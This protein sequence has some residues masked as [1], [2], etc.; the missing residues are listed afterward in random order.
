M[1]DLVSVSNLTK[2]YRVKKGLWRKKEIYAL[3]EVSLSVKEGE[4]LAVVGESGSGKSTLGKIILRLERPTGGSVLFRGKDVFS[5][6]KEYT[7]HVSVVFQDPRNSL[8]PRMRVKE[9]IEEPLRVHGIKERERRVREVVERVHLEEEL[10]GKKPLQLSGGQAQR[11]AI[12]RAL[13]LEPE[14]IVADEPTASLDLSIQKEILNLFT[15]LNSRGIAFLFITHDV[16]VVEKIA[17]RVAV[18][19]G[20]HLMELGKKEEVL[21]NPLNPYTRYLLESVPVK[22][23][24]QRR[25]SESFEE[26]EAEVP[27][28]GCPF[29][30]RCPEASQECR[31]TLRRV[32]V[33]GRVVSCNLY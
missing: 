7:R 26:E 27:E 13:V 6:G 21:S 32:E 20:G 17:H 14:L 8:N 5:M 23:P 2:V 30:P 31:E 3:K 28:R 10:L 16:R 19:Y 15:E 24:R 9:I 4:I 29:Y 12:A 25:Q 1:G 22:N 18:L 11:V 33:N